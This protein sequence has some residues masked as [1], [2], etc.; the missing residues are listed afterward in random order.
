MKN[1]EVD[2]KENAF[3]EKILSYLD[4]IA[5]DIESTKKEM[6][7]HQLIVDTFEKYGIKHEYIQVLKDSIEETKKFIGTLED[8]QKKAKDLRR[9]IKGDMVITMD[10]FC[11]LMVDVL[12]QQTVNYVEL[13][14]EYENVSKKWKVN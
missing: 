12:A 3:E 5:E 2:I 11:M 7:F 4:K 8:K 13:K 9:F 1:V 10:E 6:A 14:Q